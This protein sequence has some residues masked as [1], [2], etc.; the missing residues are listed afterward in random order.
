MKVPY[1]K[2]KD[3]NSYVKRYFQEDSPVKRDEIILEMSDD[4]CFYTP[5]FKCTYEGYI[6]YIQDYIQHNIRHFNNK[7]ILAIIVPSD[8]FKFDILLDNGNIVSVSGLFP[9]KTKSI[10]CEIQKKPLYMVLDIFKSIRNFCVFISDSRKQYVLVPDK[11]MPKFIEKYMKLNFKC[12]PS[13]GFYKC[14]S[15]T[16]SGCELFEPGEYSESIGFYMNTISGYLQ[17]YISG[18]DIDK[19]LSKEESAKIK[20]LRLDYEKNSVLDAIEEMYAMHPE[21][22]LDVLNSIDD[23]AKLKLSIT[24]KLK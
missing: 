18:I 10:R 17:R 5:N 7:K 24:G 20:Q 1:D 13:T 16:L 23:A 22:M 4:R 19:Y 21:A 9:P 11:K 15:G 6:K 3:M 2:L 8:L 14:T 12:D